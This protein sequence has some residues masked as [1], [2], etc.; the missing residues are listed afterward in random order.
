MLLSA[1]MY[2]HFNFV[3]LIAKLE[4][5]T[6]YLKH[7]FNEYSAEYTYVSVHNMTRM[8]SIL[9]FRKRIP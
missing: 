7:K 8:I 2:K 3:I 1:R 4:N 6:E 9:L 5:D